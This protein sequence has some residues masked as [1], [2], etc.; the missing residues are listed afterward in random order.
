MDI[1]IVNPSDSFPAGTGAYSV[2]QNEDGITL[3]ARENWWK[4]ETP[5]FNHIKLYAVN[6]LDELIY[7]FESF[8]IDVITM[9]STGNPIRLRG[10][11]ETRDFGTTVMQYIFNMKRICSKTRLYGRRFPV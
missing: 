4:N 7:N 3:V 11:Y 6:N 1:P 8:N 2:W 9:D 10:D 5:K